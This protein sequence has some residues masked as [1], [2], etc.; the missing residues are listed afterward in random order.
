M[1]Y[2]AVGCIVTLTLSL[3]AVPLTAQAQV[4]EKTPRVGV[5]EP[6]SQQHPFPC[7][8]AFQ[9]G[10]RDLGYIEGHNI[11]LEYRYAENQPDWLPTLAAELV[12]RQPDTIWT[13][14]SSAAQAL[15]QATTTIPIVVG[16]SVDLVEQG[17]VES[18]A[19][20]GGNLTG[21]DTQYL[22]LTSKRLE[23]LKD[24]VPQIT[25]VAILV[26]PTG[27]SRVSDRIPSAFEGEAWAL[28]L[29]LLRVET[30]EPGALDAAFTTMVEQRADALVLMD[31]RIFRTHRHRLL[32]LTLLHRLPTMAPIRSYAEAG[33]L[34]AYGADPSDLCRRSAVFVD[35]ILKGTK[36][37]DLPVE[38]AD[39]FA[40]IVNLKTAQAL[41]L[42]LSPMF[43]SRADEVIK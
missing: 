1:W 14:S 34:L 10:L 33:S 19:R 18:L 35:K 2:S 3:L 30:S 43:L 28:G 23:L 36:P 41:G 24:A 31:S 9:Q 42:T 32:E 26:D 38:R 16:V 22:E 20:P 6:G 8:P 11:F 5:L 39:T 27:T 37:A 40:L 25:R 17:L 29:H 4:R 21:L 12:Q 15:K 13:S 7:L